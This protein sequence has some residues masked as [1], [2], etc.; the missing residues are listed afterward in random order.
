MT[1]EIPGAKADVSAMTPDEKIR[2]LMNRLSKTRTGLMS[3]Q[4]YVD[5]AHEIP[6][7]VVDR[8]SELIDETL[9]VR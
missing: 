4:A 6:D 7:H 9:S 1:D 5:D 2:S 3:I 8:L